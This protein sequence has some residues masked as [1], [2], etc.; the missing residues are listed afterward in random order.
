MKEKKERPKEIGEKRKG[1]PRRIDMYD[2]KN[3]AKDKV[4]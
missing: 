2:W 3:K 1:T 4:L